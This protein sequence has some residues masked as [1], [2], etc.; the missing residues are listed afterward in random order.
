M[1]TPD[2]FDLQ[3]ILQGAKTGSRGPGRQAG[4]EA[5]DRSGRFVTIETLANRRLGPEYQRS[6]TRL[7]VHTAIHVVATNWGDWLIA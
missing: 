4:R 7:L 6:A 2:S 5:S 1:P 3:D